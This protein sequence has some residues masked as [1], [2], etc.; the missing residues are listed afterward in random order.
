VITQN[1]SR[2]AIRSRSVILCIDDQQTGLELRKRMLEKAGYSVLTAA[3]AHRALETFRAN[4]I[5][6]VLTEHVL[7]TIVGGPTLAATMKMLKPE[8]PVA[9][10]SADLWEWPDDRR[11][12]DVFI[13]KLISVDELL[14]AIQKLLVK[15]RTVV[16]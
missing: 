1:H 3:S 12:A 14:R 16:A 15:A 13:T 2:S 10:L 7:P 4:H 6:L 9:V 8:V 11:F 5:D